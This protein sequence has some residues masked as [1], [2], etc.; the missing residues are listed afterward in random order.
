MGSTRPLTRSALLCAALV[1]TTAATGDRSA[2]YP[3]TP[4]QKADIVRQLKDKLLDGESARWR[5]P[6]HQP[7]W[8][9]YCGWYN[10]KNSYGAFVGW[11]PFLA[12][13]G[14]GSDL[15]KDEFIVAFSQ[16][17]SA[18][19]D[20]S[21]AAVVADQCTKGGYDMAAPPPER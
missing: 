18:D 2:P 20:D 12:A 14:Q 10:A 5:W 16:M 1:M 6:L 17:G 21:S 13:G 7:A 9:L 19:A 8:G 4:R 3:L 11:Q 15:K